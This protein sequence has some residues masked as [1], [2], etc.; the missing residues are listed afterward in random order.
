MVSIDWWWIV[1]CFTVSFWWQTLDRDLA[2]T[3]V[4]VIAK[5]TFFLTLLVV[6]FGIPRNFAFDFGVLAGA[7][8]IVTV[9]QGILP[10]PLKSAS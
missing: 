7:M 4:I 10:M 8:L 6:V 9:V 1:F 2:Q 5:C 3:M